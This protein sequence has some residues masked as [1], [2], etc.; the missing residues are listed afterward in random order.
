VCPDCDGDGC[1]TCRR[2]D[3]IAR[4]GDRW[5]LEPWE[6][7]S[8]LIIGSRRWWGSTR[9][10]RCR[11][12]ACN[13]SRSK[14]FRTVEAAA[15]D[16]LEVGEDLDNAR[17]AAELA[18]AHRPREG[19]PRYSPP[20]PMGVAGLRTRRARAPVAGQSGGTTRTRG[21]GAGGGASRARSEP[22]CRR[23]R[24][25]TPRGRAELAA[26]RAV[27]RAAA[28]KAAQLAAQ[29]EAKEQAERWRLAKIARQEAAG[30][31]PAAYPEGRRT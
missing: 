6:E 28:R 27:E 23:R 2:P 24:R 7:A 25:A 8:I 4:L 15:A 9:D 3:Q 30:P 20:H 12:L 13:L 19:W 18:A 11:C 5:P 26:A 14:V 1:V 29:A 31:R 17:A 21:P 16:R 22:R 10:P